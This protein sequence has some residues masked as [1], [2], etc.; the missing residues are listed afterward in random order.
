MTYGQYPPF[1]TWID[2]SCRKEGENGTNGT[3][4]ALTIDPAQEELKTFVPT[5]CFY[6]EGEYFKP[7]YDF[8]GSNWFNV[9]LWLHGSKIFTGSKEGLGVKDDSDSV[10]KVTWEFKQHSQSSWK[11]K[12]F[13]KVEGDTFSIKLDSN[14]YLCDDNL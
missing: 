7:L 10:Y 14:G 1:R 4:Y 12:S 11:E 6:S 2:I 9:S 8:S 3:G 13:Y 5:I